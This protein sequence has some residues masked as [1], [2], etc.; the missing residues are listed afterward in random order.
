VTDPGFTVVAQGRRKSSWRLTESRSMPSTAL[1][2]YR[3]GTDRADRAGRRGRTTLMRMMAGLLTG[4]GTAQVGEDVSHAS[5]KAV[6]PH[7]LHA[8]SASAFTKTERA[9]KPDALCRPP[10]PM[11]QRRAFSR[12]LK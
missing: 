9:G 10:A 5:P 2:P 1:V 6:Q 3:A 4:A 12:M 8:G 11:E 7:R